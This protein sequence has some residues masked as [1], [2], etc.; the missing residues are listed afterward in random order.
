MNS[1]KGFTLVETL[2]YIVIASILLGTIMNVQMSVF[3]VSKQLRVA[4]EVQQ[5]VRFLTNIISNRLHNVT[6][7][8]DI[9]PASEVV[10]FYPDTEHRWLLRSSDGHLELL[11]QVYNQ[12]TSSWVD[13]AGGYQAVT[14]DKAVISNWSII[15]VKNAVGSKYT[16]AQISFTLTIGSAQEP[17][18][19]YQGNY[20]MIAG[21]RN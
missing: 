13:V 15:P 2:V 10:R 19:Y 21:A 4:H 20:Q 3:R 11:D 16:S 7:I 14:T 9:R 1:S 12:G 17:F 6:S 18:G 8:E 5:N